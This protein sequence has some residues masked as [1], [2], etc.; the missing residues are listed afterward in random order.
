MNKQQIK[1][2]YQPLQLEVIAFEAKA[3]LMEGTSLDGNAGSAE[4]DDQVLDAPRD[5]FSNEE[6]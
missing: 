2:S 5:P 1:L 4:D 3:Q 6:N